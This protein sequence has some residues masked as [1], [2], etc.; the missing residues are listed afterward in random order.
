MLFIFQI[1]LDNEEFED[2]TTKFNVESI[3]YFVAFKDGKQIGTVAGAN[4]AK[5]NALVGKQ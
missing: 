1:D 5:L 2:L 4:K 3:P